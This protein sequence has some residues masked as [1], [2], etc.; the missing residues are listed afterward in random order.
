[1]T[2]VTKLTFESGD[3]AVLDDVVTD[4]KQLLER[5]GAECKGP[6]SSP[7]ERLSVPQYRTLERG[8]EFSSWSYTVYTRRLEIHGADQIARSVAERSFPDSVHVE[9]EIEQK[10]PLGHR[11]N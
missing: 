8:R 3:R 11:Q 6:H 2:F 7:P 9:L 5:K 10:K 1:M 4:L